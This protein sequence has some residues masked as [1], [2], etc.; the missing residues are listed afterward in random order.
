MIAVVA[1]ATGLTGKALIEELLKDP[2]VTRVVALV[3]ARHGLPSH[4]KLQEASFEEGAT[5]DVYFCCIGTT[6]RKAGSRGAFRRS[7]FD[8]VMA[9]AKLCETRGGRSFVLVSAMGANPRAFTF[10]SRVKGEA[11][12]AVASLRIPRVIIARPSL[13]IGER[14]EKRP[15]ERAAI[16]AWKVLAPWMPAGLRLRSGTPIP[17]LARRLVQESLSDG[18]SRQVLLAH[19]LWG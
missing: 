19:E 10:Y 1:G 7:D 16:E 2:R 9:F 12:E 13:L 17:G 6:I 11:E 15:A 5:G 3:R 14:S 4:P 8:A 18:P